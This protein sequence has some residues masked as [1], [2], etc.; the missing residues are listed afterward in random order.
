MYL[1]ECVVAKGYGRISGGGTRVLELAAES[2]GMALGYGARSTS[3]SLLTS[4]RPKGGI[5][6]PKTRVVATGGAARYGGGFGEPPPE[7]LVRR[8]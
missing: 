7:T 6:T 5:T 3:T 4:S 8:V 2:R 1:H